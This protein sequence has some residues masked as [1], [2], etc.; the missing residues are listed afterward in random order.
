MHCELFFNSFQV[1]SSA[2]GVGLVSVSALHL[3]L[4]PLLW[5]EIPVFRGPRRGHYVFPPRDQVNSLT[6]ERTGVELFG[7]GMSLGSKITR[8]IAGEQTSLQGRVLFIFI[9]IFLSVCEK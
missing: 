2:C 6:P 1:T 3:F 9:F 8:H 5:F 4:C 7:T